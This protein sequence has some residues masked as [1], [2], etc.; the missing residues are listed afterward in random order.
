MREYWDMYFQK[1]L[2]YVWSSVIIRL[3]VMYQSIT[4][5]F[6]NWTLYC[7]EALRESD[8]ANKIGAKLGT[9]CKL[10]VF[11]CKDFI[12]DSSGSFW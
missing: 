3:Y 5:I 8:M 4:E 1:I 10:T 2:G 6:L 7:R 12:P 11:V 9:K